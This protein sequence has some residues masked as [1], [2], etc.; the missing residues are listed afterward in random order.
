[1]KY[2]V[3]IG[4]YNYIFDERDVALEFAETAFETQE[5]NQRISFSFEREEKA[6][7]DGNE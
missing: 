5:D 7:E 6:E 1:M 2:I 4:Y 3:K